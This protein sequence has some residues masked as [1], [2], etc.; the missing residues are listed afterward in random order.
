MSMIRHNE[1]SFHENFIM[2]KRVQHLHLIINWLFS[3]SQTEPTCATHI[4]RLL[5]QRLQLKAKWGFSKFLFHATV[6]RD[7]VSKDSE[8]CLFNITH[9]QIL[10][11]LISSMTASSPTFLRT[12]A[13]FFPLSPAKFFSLG[14]PSIVYEGCRIQKRCL[15]VRMKE[16]SK[17]ASQ[18]KQGGR[19]R[20]RKNFL[21]EVCAFSPHPPA[22]LPVMPCRRTVGWEGEKLFSLNFEVHTH[23]KR[24]RFRKTSWAGFIP[25][26]PNGLI[27]IGFYD[28]THLK[29]RHRLRRQNK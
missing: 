29:S 28:N 5:L 13:Y 25:K 15:V 7:E 24:L 3:Y 23:I 4:F 26:Y 16:A 21:T 14:L 9:F 11:P 27:Y 18:A 12:L 10:L 6:D 2:F 22:T 17:S 1:F 19:N 20:R 8:K